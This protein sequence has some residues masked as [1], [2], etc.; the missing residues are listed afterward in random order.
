[1]QR[2]DRAYQ[3]RFDLKETFHGTS[4]RFQCSFRAGGGAGDQFDI[5]A[6][7]GAQSQHGGKC[8]FLG[9][10]YDQACDNVFDFHESREIR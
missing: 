1:M 10:A 8:V 7:N 2:G 5:Y 6:G 3:I 9:T 4:Y